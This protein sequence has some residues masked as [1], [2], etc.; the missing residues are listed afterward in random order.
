MG[1]S[2]A[3]D[4]EATTIAAKGP[5]T[6]AAKTVGRTDIDTESVVVERDSASLGDCRDCRQAGDG[7]RASESVRN[8]F[9]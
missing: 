8:G 7:Q 5:N 6:A 9:D 2:P 4:N 3:T 1:K